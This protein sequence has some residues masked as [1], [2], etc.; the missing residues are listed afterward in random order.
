M[1][2][3]VTLI[4][5][6]LGFTFLGL[7]A[8][9]F[10][11]TQ[12]FNAVSL[13]VGKSSVFSAEI[14]VYGIFSILPIIFMTSSMFLSFYKTRHLSSPVSSCIT[15]A[16]LSLVTWFVFYPVTLI[17]QE[18]AITILTPIEEL[19]STQDLSGGYFRNINGT[20]YYFI[21]DSKDDIA[22][23]ARLYDSKSPNE[24]AKVGTISVS[25]TSN[26]S[27]AEAH[28]NDPIIR[29][30]MGSMPMNI[31][32]IF[33]FYKNKAER[34][35]DTGIISWLFFCSMGLALS[36]VYGL[37]RV[38]SW[39]LINTVWILL[40]SVLILWFN[41]LYFQPLFGQIRRTV[42]NFLFEPGKSNFFLDNEIEL[43]LFC[44]NILISIILILIGILRTASH[45]NRSL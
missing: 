24:F 11:F 40:T 19:E 10:L 2:K 9:L 6:Y 41:F 13:V 7:L 23:V 43:P 16:L 42:N 15:Y 35:W 29:E 37:L 14:L 12:Y 4:L 44:V 39:K 25:S 3:P 8:G 26:F 34:M 31:S 17:I 18:R 5:Y 36:S 27:E 20:V 38:S 21:K 1:S 45:K 28:F 30:S 32:R 22:E 33:V